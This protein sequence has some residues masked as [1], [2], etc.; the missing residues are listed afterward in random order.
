MK[1]SRQIT[2]RQADSANPQPKEYT[3][4]DY[5]VPGFGLRV[6]PSGARTFIYAYRGHGG[7][8]RRFKIGPPT[9]FS[10]KEARLS[11]KYLAQ[12]VYGG[13]DPADL[14][15]KTLKSNVRELFESYEESRV[16]GFSEGHRV[17]IIAI[18]R[19][20][21]LPQIGHK[22]IGT[23][24]RIDIK[25][26]TDKKKST[27]KKAMANN[28]HRA[29]SAFMTWCCY[30]A[31]VLDS[32]PIKGM[33]LPARKVSRDRYL[34]PNELATLWRLCDRLDTKWKVGIRLLMLTG[35]RSSE[36][37]GSKIEEFDLEAGKWQIPSYRTK[38]RR[39]HTVFLSPAAISEIKRVQLRKG[40]TYLFQS[41]R[42][43]RPTPVSG[44]SGGARVI[45][46]LAPFNDWCLHDLRRSVA[47][48]MASLGVAP[49]IIQVVLNH[50]SGF[51]SGVTA[52]YNRYEYS[53]EA[54]FAWQIWEKALIDWTQEHDNYVYKSM[55]DDDVVI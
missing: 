54:S 35:Q 45:K 15:E 47:T 4:W 40:Q 27:G 32:N 46:K 12:Q 10:V 26:I 5:Y 48:H 51:R 42:T 13:D 41:D 16:Q 49:H 3:I 8:Q 6:R 1:S 9:V 14:K 7:K 44:S 43:I 55:G 52:I 38:N 30:E 25:K 2:Q 34:T 11:A 37:F 22:P 23:V 36:V 53:K 21:I 17:R 39:T 24:N 28:I 29:I 18:F 20:E 19:N 33:P 31:F 50:R